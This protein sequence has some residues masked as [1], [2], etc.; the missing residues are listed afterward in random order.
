MKYLYC[1]TFICRDAKGKPYHYPPQFKNVWNEDEAVG[2][3]ARLVKKVK[4]E[5]PNMVHVEC[6][7]HN[8]SDK[9]LELV[10]AMAVEKEG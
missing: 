6:F 4:T 10:A 2:Y 9:V 5:Y 1:F 8:V 3:A 7:E